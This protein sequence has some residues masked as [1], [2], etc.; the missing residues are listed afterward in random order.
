MTVKL[1]DENEVSGNYTSIAAS[2]AARGKG[3]I[4]GRQGDSQFGNIN[5]QYKRHEANTG[6]GNFEFCFVDHETD[7][8]VTLN[9]FHF[10]I[11][12]LDQ[13]GGDNGNNGVGIKE[14]FIFDARQVTSYSLFPNWLDSE[15]KPI[16]ANN[17]A[18]NC[19]D[20]QC[21]GVT[22][23]AGTCPEGIS[24]VFRSSRSGGGGDNPVDPN[25][26]TPLMRSRAINLHF[27]NKSCFS[28]SY[29]L[30]CPF[31]HPH[32]AID[33]YVG[34]KLNEE[35][36]CRMNADGYAGGHFLFAGVSD[37]LFHDPECTPLPTQSP[38]EPPAPVEPPTEPPVPYVGTCSAGDGNGNDNLF[39]VMKM[40]LRTSLGYTNAV[41]DMFKEVN[42]IETL[43]Q[44]KYDLTA[45]FCVDTFA[46]EPKDKVQTQGSKSYGLEAWLC[47]P[48][49]TEYDENLDRTVPKK[50]TSYAP[51][52]VTGLKALGGDAFEQGSLINVCVA[53]DEPTHNDGVV[54]SALKDFT[55]YRD[56]PFVVEQEAITN[57][58]ASILTSYDPTACNGQEWCTFASVLFADFYSSPGSV[59]GNGNANLEFAEIRRKLRGVEEEGRQLQDADVPS[60]FDV[61]VLVSG[62]YDGPGALRTAGG[63]SFGLSLLVSAVALVVAA[64]LA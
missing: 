32:S 37:A 16:C 21:E 46:V 60:P 7:A 36:P 43:I 50:I 2:W 8:P 20:G 29:S 1:F 49:D 22:N 13:R 54:I 41:T 33:H 51:D 9:D 23:P 53:P 17:E 56:A 28:I 11:W 58:A 45:G 19:D 40:C 47:D 59:Y 15:V 18:I 24:T 27:E 31:E 14:K 26:L 5:L 35:T 30:Y 61:N 4:N 42:F 10:T 12:D 44:I 39:G 55:W 6:T 48:E 38:V 34:R 52:P 3:I 64:L 62:L 63:A 25:D 57:S